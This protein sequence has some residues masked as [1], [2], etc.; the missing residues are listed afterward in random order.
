MYM[1]RYHLYF[2]V[3]V[4]H[5]ESVTIYIHPELIATRYYVNIYYQRC[6]KLP[7]HLTER[8]LFIQGTVYVK[9]KV[10]RHSKWNDLEYGNP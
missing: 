3:Y 10:R 6:V 9:T 7:P 1:V 5:K 8:V 4:K 2:V